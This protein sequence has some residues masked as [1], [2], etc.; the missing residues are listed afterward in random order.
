VVP[1]SLKNF[2]VKDSPMLNPK[3][4]MAHSPQPVMISYE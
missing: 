2:L 4:T 1:F 3:Q